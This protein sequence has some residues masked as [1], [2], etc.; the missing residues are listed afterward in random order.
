MVIIKLYIKIGGILMKDIDIIAQLGDLKN[1]DYKNTLAIATLIELLV[2]NG[3][4]T[5]QEFARKAQQ[6]DHMSLE[7]LKNIRSNSNRAMNL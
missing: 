5:R 4:I 6:L 1:I 2:E 7:E 3:L